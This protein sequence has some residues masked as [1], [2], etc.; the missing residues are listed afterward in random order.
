MAVAPWSR[1][2]FIKR[3][4]ND[5][6]RS[7]LCW[8]LIALAAFLGC[9]GSVTNSAETEAGASVGPGSGGA[10]ASGGGGE[11]TVGSCIG[12]SGCGVG[13]A[14]CP[15]FT[16]KPDASMTQDPAPITDAGAATCEGW[17]L[18]EGTFTFVS[19][20]NG[21]SCGIRTDGTVACWGHPSYA[22]SEIPSGNFLRISADFCTCGVRAS[23]ELACWGCKVPPPPGTFQDVGRGEQDRC[24]L[25]TD[26]TMI[27]W[28]SANPHV[29]SY[30]FDSMS[31][32]AYY[33][34]AL[35]T[36]GHAAVCWDPRV[37][38]V[39]LKS[40]PFRQVS[41]GRFSACGVL[42]DSTVTCWPLGVTGTILTPQ[43]SPFREISVGEYS[44]CGL[45][46]DGSIACWGMNQYGEATPPAGAR[47]LHVAVGTMQACGILLDGTLKCWGSAGDPCIS[48]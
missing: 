47:F 6:T 2:A 31:E 43:P 38:E 30:K 1:A 44:V 35:E 11:E 33:T 8:G 7:N 13:G 25:G 28:G 16:D 14:C 24:A 29:P 15:G 10:S 17:P 19:S 37:G 21:S 40:G 32:G 45:R 12:G 9:G 36:S 4:G 41:A 20:G 23:G 22:R 27:C 26:G 46:D 48:G 39:T 3:R 34:C 18:P 5:T 42:M